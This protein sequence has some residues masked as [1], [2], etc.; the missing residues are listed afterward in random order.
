MAVVLSLGVFGSL[1]FEAP[2]CSRY[3]TGESA[4]DDR[5]QGKKLGHRY[6]PTK[7]SNIQ[8]AQPTIGGMEAIRNPVITRFLRLRSRNC[9]LAIDEPIRKQ[10]PRIINHVRLMRF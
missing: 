10:M 5:S 3:W 7:G 4:K 8:I 2:V 6:W 9:T 1:P